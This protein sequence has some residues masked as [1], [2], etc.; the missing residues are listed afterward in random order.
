MK[1]AQ[2]FLLSIR[3]AH[4][5]NKTENIGFIGIGNM[6]YPMAQNILKHD[7]LNKYNL[8]LSD[9]SQDVMKQIK[10]DFDKNRCDVVD[11]PCQVAEKALQIITMLPDGDC[12]EEAYLGSNGLIKN[13]TKNHLCIDSSTISPS[14][15]LK[16]SKI[17]KK[18]KQ[19]SFIDAPVSGG[20]PGA[21]NATLTFMAGGSDAD[22]KRASAI[23]TP[24][25]GK[26]LF[27]C[28]KEVGS[29]L[30]AKL[31]N[32]MLLA[33]CMIGTSEA[34]NLGRT[35]GLDPKVLTDIINESTGKN[36]CSSSY[37]PVPGMLSGE[38]AN[39]PPN[40]DY[41][42]GFRVSLMCKDLTLGQ[43]IANNKSVY[44]P[45]G[46]VAH[47]IYKYLNANP[48]A[49]QKDF[50]YVYPFISGKLLGRKH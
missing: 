1:I 28:G 16:I 30:S 18:E 27:H 5:S 19:A 37:N 39:I 9:N 8:V 17:L 7:K 3:Y 6:G 13:L 50:A 14:T 44:C 46:S 35:L 4:S 12:V 29:G 23:I 36:W 20:V 26:K 49:S 15:A 2:R 21:V 40:L 43:N 34:L 33:I 47:Q 10:K 32:N 24:F 48:D 38:Y 11:T 41:A 31:C 25:M 45:L 42:K 22:V